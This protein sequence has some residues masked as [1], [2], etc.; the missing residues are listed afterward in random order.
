M[1][2]TKPTK[3]ALLLCILEILKRHS[4]SKRRLTQSEIIDYL[5]NEYDLVC[6]RKTIARNID[7]LLDL[8]YDIETPRDGKKG[9]VY[10][11]RDFVEGELRMLIDSVLSFRY[12]P[13]KYA[14]D[15][16]NK[17][18]QL[19]T[20]EFKNKARHVHKVGE[21]PRCNNKN[22]FLNI[23]I[24]AEAIERKRK[25]SFIYNDYGVDKKLHPRREE[26][27]LVSPYH[28]ILHNQRYYLVL[29]MDKYDDIAC[30]RIDQIS[31]IEITNKPIRS[32][33]TIKG[34]ENGIDLGKISIQ[35]PYLYLSTD[36][37]RIVAKAPKELIGD[38]LDWFGPSI[39]I[40][41]I[42]DGQI[43]VRLKSS[44]EGMRFWA[45]QYGPNVEILEPQKLRD[46][47][48]QDVLE[49]Y[50][51]YCGGVECNA[52]NIHTQ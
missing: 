27:Y 43:L 33:Q 21:W 41:D 26:R 31:D 5:K 36:V 49:M 35:H 3:K 13:Q 25:I 46:M 52:I 51:K 48:R 30:Y 24:I 12:I 18:L 4:H 17:L 1:V 22:I 23:D 20:D 38:F 28:M 42:G 37:E 44:L 32:L 11:G 29:N 34:Y 15:L 39:D 16:V 8:G 50:R 10:Q 47:L 9:Y 45:L 19:G 6:D 2:P 40:R 14:R 7:V